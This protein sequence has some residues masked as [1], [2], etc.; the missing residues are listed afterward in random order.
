MNMTDYEK[1]YNFQYLYN[2]HKVARLGKR[3]VKEVIDFKLNLAKDLMRISDA[4]RDKTYTMSGYYS[5]YVHDPKERI[6][7]AWLLCD[8]RHISPL[9]W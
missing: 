8:C 4:L 7:R 2:A 5:F 3:D 9:W 1:I 6:L